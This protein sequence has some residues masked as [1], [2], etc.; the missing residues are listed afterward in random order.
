M[1]DAIMI[2]SF[3]IFALVTLFIIWRP[4]GIQEFLPATIGAVAFVALGIVSI[5]DLYSVLGIVSGASL[6]ILSTIIMSIV[7]ESVGFFRWAAFNIALKARGSGFVLFWYIN[8]L[9]F[10]MTLFFNNDGSILITTPIILKTL[11]ILN[12]R[13][14]QKLPYLIS[15]ALI[16]TGASAPIGVSNLA[17]LIALKIVG[18]D[19]NSYA[20]MMFIPAMA[21]IA[22]IAFL[23]FLSFKNVI[24]RKIPLMPASSIQNLT[25]M[26][27]G[28]ESKKKYHPL[29]YNPDNNPLMNVKMFRICLSIVIL[30]RISFFVLAPLNISTEWPAVIGAILLI[31]ISRR[32]QGVRIV[33]ILKKTPWQILL[34][35]FSVYV[36]IY[37]LHNSGLT[38]ILVHHLENIVSENHFNAIFSMGFL[39]TIMSNICNN[40]PSVMIGTLA[41]TEMNLDPSTLQI[42]YLANI[43]GADIGSLILPMGTLAS[44]IWM[45]ILKEHGVPISWRKYIQTSIWIVPL[46]LIGSLICLYLWNYYVIF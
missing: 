4:F 35:A 46:G 3:S 23:L 18:L 5:P 20:I 32:Q 11:S 26:Y 22:I 36:V 10:L 38:T 25:E 43:I 19:L 12:L 45:H 39:L 34:F 42:S 27:N 2:L 30:V 31:L 6:T 9:C 33:H 41:L 15:G 14:H 13:P 8:L 24:P 44:L 40:L 28:P 16:A 37:G 1:P 7:L 17:N 29:Q 21:G